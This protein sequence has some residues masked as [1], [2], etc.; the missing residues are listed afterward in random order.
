MI[1]YIYIYMYIYI[2]KQLISLHA[3]KKNSFYE[4]KITWFSYSILLVL[5]NDD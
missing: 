2:Y 1:I 3:D 5:R 4:E